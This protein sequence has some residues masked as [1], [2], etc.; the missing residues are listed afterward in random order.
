[1]VQENKMCREAGKGDPAVFVYLTTI[2]SY[3]TYIM[4]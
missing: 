4:F 1:M 3:F 2:M